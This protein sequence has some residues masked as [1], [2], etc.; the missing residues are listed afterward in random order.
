MPLCSGSASSS[1][2][3]IAPSRSAPVLV[4]FLRRHCI[5]RVSRTPV[6]L[7]SVPL[8]SAP[9]GSAPAPA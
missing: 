6:R 8:G 1:P 7:S 2:P 3:G 9:P 5:L 4:V